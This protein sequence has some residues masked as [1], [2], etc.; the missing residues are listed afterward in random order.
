MFKACQALASRHV[1]CMSHLRRMLRKRPS[2]CRSS[3]SCQSVTLLPRGSALGAG[4]SGLNVAS[5][6]TKSGSQRPCILWNST[7]SQAVPAHGQPLLRFRNIELFMHEGKAAKICM[8]PHQ[9][10]ESYELFPALQ[11]ASCN[12][13]N[14]LWHSVRGLPAISTAH[15]RTAAIA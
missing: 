13:I 8:M 6:K 2:S 11:T 3:P 7:C 14:L 15:S 5:E 9:M 4:R 1:G 10:A 12:L